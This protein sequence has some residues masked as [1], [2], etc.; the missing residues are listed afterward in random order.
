MHPSKTLK[1]SSNR[2]SQSVTLDGFS[3]YSFVDTFSSLEGLKSHVKQIVE[4]VSWLV[5]S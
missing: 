3:Q 2:S 5:E 4:L 1:K